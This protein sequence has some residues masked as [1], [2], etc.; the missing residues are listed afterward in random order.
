[1]SGPDALFSLRNKFLLGAYQAA[2]NEGNVGGLT[3]AEAVEKDV[4]VYR[5]Y[6]ALGSHQLVTDEIG[7]SAPTAL[8]AIK[9]LALYLSGADGKDQA[10]SSLQELL[11]DAAL[12][13]NPTLLLVAGTI[14]SHEQNYT[15]ALKFTN[16]GSTLD[17][18]ALNV[19]IFLKM[20][21][22]DYAEKQLKSMQHIDEDATLTQLSNAWVNLALGGTKIQ[23]AFYIFQEL[24][25]KYMWTVLLLN[26]NAV[27]QMH[28]GNY[29][30]A[31]KLLL[32]ALNKDGKD[33]NTLANL[34][35][36]CLHLG[37]PISR[38]FNQLRTVAA[39]HALITRSNAA[40]AN[41]EQALVAY[42]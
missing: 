8:Q 1:M 39:D 33:A 26:G 40:E 4:L 38:H 16:S 22:V 32:D 24:G 13:N 17:L 20:D 11:S 3:D 28:M 37:K 21:R 18:C 15:E 36:C 5:S 7:P 34:V 12:L 23:E 9:I 19:Q 30:E 2:I 6:L 29:E 10:L 35:V 31:E 27:C 42:A 14:Y 41:F 25:E